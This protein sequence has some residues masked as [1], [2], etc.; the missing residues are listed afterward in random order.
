MAFVLSSGG[1][2]GPEVPFWL[3][4]LCPRGFTR[5]LNPQLDFRSRACAIAVVVGIAVLG[6][7]AEAADA[8]PLDQSWTGFSVAAGGGAA[9]I[10]PQINSSDSRTDKVGTCRSGTVEQEDF[11]VHLD[12]FFDVPCDPPGSATPVLDLSEKASSRTDFDEMGGFFTAQGAYDYQFA[13]R[14]VAGAFLDADW[15]S[16]RAHAKQAQTSAQKQTTTSSVLLGETPTLITSNAEGFVENTTIDALISTDW[17][18]SVGGR[19]G[20]LATQG[21]LFYFLAGYTHA[22]LDDARVKVSFA[23]PLNGLGN[24]NSFSNSPTGLLVRLPGSLDGFSL[25]GGAEAKLHGPWRLKFEY[26]WTHLAGGSGRVSSADSQSVPTM[27]LCELGQP[28]ECF[29]LLDHR[30]I[31]SQASANFDLDIQT[32]RAE[33]VYHFWSGRWGHGDD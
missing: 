20:W 5:G 9:L 16:I 21:M 23:D 13:P 27:E 22:E 26:R 6:T 3:P 31:K 11:S 8:K 29:A 14:W 19:L 33:L 15:S 2:L 1:P 28:A 12:N 4:I 24:A 7:P 17:S 18:V 10:S 30:D 32:V 25:G